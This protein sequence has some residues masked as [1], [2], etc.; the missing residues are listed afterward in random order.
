M[1]TYPEFYI[2]VP[3]KGFLIIRGNE[4]D[5]RGGVKIK[6]W[7]KISTAEKWL[8]KVRPLF[9]TAMIVDNTITID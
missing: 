4:W 1:K 9:P 8:E 7:S 6:T 2:Q 5:I 3:T